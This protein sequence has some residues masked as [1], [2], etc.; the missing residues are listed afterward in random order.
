MSQFLPVLAAVNST[1]ALVTFLIYSTAVLGLALASHYVL[2]KTNFMDDYF[3][4]SR[5]LGP[6]A[7]MLTFA[8]T[9]ASAGSF[10]G[11]PSL[12]YAHG[13]VVALWIA[14]Y[15][16]V[17]LVSMGLLGKRINRVARQAGAI[18]L[19]DLLFARFGSRAV[20][21]IATVLLVSLLS[22][23]LVP[24][25]KLGSI[26][27]LELLANVKVWQ[28]TVL[29][30]GD[31]TSQIPLIAHVDPGYLLGL[32]VFSLTVVAYTSVGGFRAVVWTDMLQGIVMFFGVIALLVLVIIQV[33]GLGNATRTLA[34]IT[35]PQLV[36]LELR[37]TTDSAP[38]FIPSETWIT[39]GDGDDQRLFRINESARI[40]ADG[41]VSSRI[42]AV[43]ITGEFE[44]NMR[45][46]QIAGKPDVML[47]ESIAVTVAEEKAYRGGAD[48]KGA[49]IMAP[50]PSENSEAGFLPLTIAFSFFVFWTFGAAGQ[51]GNKVRL[52]AFD[53]TR[54]LKKAMALLVVYYG[55][56]YFS[57]V[58]IFSC[59]RLLV[60]AL[61]QTPDRIMP[62]LS[63]TVANNAGIPWLAGILIAAPFAAAMSTVDSFML[64]ISSSLV[65]DV[66][67]REFNPDVSEK[68][69]KTL[70]YVC[71]AGIGVLVMLAA[72]NPPRFLQ[73]VIIF[74]A[75][76]LASVYLMPVFLA[77]F[78]PR[79]NSA[80][81][82]AGMLGGLA[83]CMLLYIIGYVTAYLGGV[84]SL[85]AMSPLKPLGFDPMVWGIAGSGAIAVIAA[86]A[87]P[88]PADENVR[89]FF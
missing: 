40:P 58:V 8:A 59:G 51:P 49:Y 82:I 12:V 77:L 53:S 71:T 72:I 46:E 10:A 78:W 74:A 33:G 20:S 14:G 19:P 62:V 47:P 85:S 86:L 16:T 34:E 81:A 29:A 76:G 37:G 15:M 39:L 60:P 63:M 25:F 9:S 21:I 36:Q 56:I 38:R 69:T 84:T 65:R 44:K 32:L 7:F 41:A 30:F 1:D 61:D 31:V 75:S 80:G 73:V 79:F 28:Q 13:W 43:E 23:F 64:M 17:P 24:Q 57:L 67:Q 55:G 11:F 26:I 83:V 4:G 87:T 70:S 88:P 48:R 42:K 27:L 5:G 66:Y 50:G 52:M 54:T 89:K 18:T 3:L 45:L 68:T 22:L 6:W 2:S 35:P